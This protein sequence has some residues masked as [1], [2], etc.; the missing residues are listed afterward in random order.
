[1]PPSSGGKERA[2]QITQTAPSTS[3]PVTVPT[4]D[5][6]L[7]VTA[8]R[9]EFNDQRQT[10]TAEGNVVVRFQG[11]VIDANRVQG[12]LRNF[13][14]VAEGDAALTRGQQVF[15]GARFTYNFIQ[16]SG[17]IQNATGTV[18]ATTSGTDL[19]F[20]TP[21]G[22]FT[23]TIPER[24][25]SDRLLEG[26]P[27]QQITNPG[28]IGIEAGTRGFSRSGNINRIRFE[29][30]EIEFY[31]RGW[32]ARGVRLTNDPF[33]PPELEL[34]ADRA[35]FTQLSP[36]RDEIRLSNSRLVFDQGLSVPT[37]QRRII[38]DRT[39]REPPLFLIRYDAR[40]RGGFYIERT[41]DLINTPRVQ[42]SFTPQFLVQ[43]T[44]TQLSGNIFN[45]A[46]Y[47]FRSG[48]DA[49]INPRTT[50]RAIANTPTLFLNELPDRLRAS[51]RLRHIIGTR[52]PH[53]LTFEYS[54]RDRLFNGS[55]GNQT[56]RSSLGGVITS[57]NIPIG[58]TGIFLTYQGGIQYVNAR[59]DRYFLLD[60][61]PV[62]FLLEDDDR[63]A[64]GRFQASAQLIRPTFLWRGKPL[65]ATA[66]QGLRYTP[67]PVVPFIQFVPLVRGTTT[68][69]TTNE[70]QNSLLF[71]VGVSGQIGHF[72]R[73]F[74]D[75]TGFNIRF[76]QI[77]RDGLSPFL[78]DRVA[79]TRILS[80]GL[81][82]QIY[83][84]IRVGFQTS[85]NLDTSEVI[86]TDYTLEY[87]RRTY[88][89][90]LRVNPERQLGSIN[91]RISDFN[92]TGAGEEPFRGSGGRLIDA[93]VIQTE[94]F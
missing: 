64:L 15:R 81:T 13:I 2:S 57:P 38:I 43:R 44:L 41:F 82:Q 71:S 4:Q 26:Q 90:I 20:T 10:F 80:F 72:S 19:T 63:L 56:V 69:Y 42:W 17:S 11:A 12:N 34:R 32:I 62:T 55:L 48:F 35:V 66:A 59:S 40:E 86:S 91:L 21:T 37:F 3:P 52:L 14:A 50:L 29:A 30:Q 1:M 47:G 6:V 53:T 7:E 25:L 89:V 84:P 76:S 70:S 23:T 61:D 28:G 74:L 88:G 49:V 65:P 18:F 75:Y 51:L 36:L 78:F 27:P 45:P 5:G 24:P 33:S 73:P 93:G 83:G 67:V 87:S 46:A 94:P 54:Y 79:D 16:N 60:P 39:Q 77:L 92:W 31:P 22:G 58:K 68:W 9:Q 8:D 85:I